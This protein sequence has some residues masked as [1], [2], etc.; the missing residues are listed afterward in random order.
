M[1]VDF[2]ATLSIEFSIASVSM[3][4]ERGHLGGCLGSDQGQKGRGARG[5]G[6]RAVGGIEGN[7][8]WTKARGDKQKPIGLES[9]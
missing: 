7:R 9:F 6:L 8:I 4:S 1:A 2:T 3:A 5:A